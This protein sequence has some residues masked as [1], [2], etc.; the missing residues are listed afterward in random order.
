MHPCILESAYVYIHLIHI[1]LITRI[2]CREKSGTERRAQAVKG[3]AEY[4]SNQVTLWIVSKIHSPWSFQFSMIMIS[5]LF[6]LIFGFHTRKNQHP[7]LTQFNI[8]ST[9]FICWNLS[10]LKTI[11]CENQASFHWKFKKVEFLSDKGSWI[12]FTEV[13]SYKMAKW[14]D[15]SYSL[16]ISWTGNAIFFLDLSPPVKGIPKN[17]ILICLFLAVFIILFDW[18]FLFS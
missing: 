2:G 4:V 3:H 15:C 17:Q 12:L 1:L 10:S 14:K 9:I 16:P 6:T 7:S 8:E 11:T 5:T 18:I 13:A